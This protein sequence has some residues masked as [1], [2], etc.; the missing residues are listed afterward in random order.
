MS[1]AKCT[2][3]RMQPTMGNS[4]L[5][6]RQ[7]ECT[8]VVCSAQAALSLT[9]RKAAAS[10]VASASLL[11]LRS[12]PKEAAL[13]STPDRCAPL[14]GLLRSDGL[15]VSSCS[16]PSSPATG[17]AHLS[18][19]T[20]IGLLSHLKQELTLSPRPVERASHRVQSETSHSVMSDGAGWTAG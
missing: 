14:E 6:R 19:G 17:L 10:S 12:E 16:S 18:Q 8:G 7:H 13:P 9:W 2:T 15:L 11:K 3:C 1:G 5:E 4:Q 20:E